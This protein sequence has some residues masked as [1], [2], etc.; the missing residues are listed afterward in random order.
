MQRPGLI[1][2]SLSLENPTIELGWSAMGLIAVVV[3]L[4][5]MAVMVW[6]RR[7]NS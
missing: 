1:N 6:Y 4:V 2:H 7:R 3:T 5:V